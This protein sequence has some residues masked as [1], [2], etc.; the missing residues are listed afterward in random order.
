MDH[1]IENLSNEEYNTLIELLSSM[2]VYINCV[3]CGKNVKRYWC[4]YSNIIKNNTIKYG[5][6]C[7]PCSS[8]AEYYREPHPSTIK[9]RI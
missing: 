6:L 7:K 5:P 3:N 2:R 4:S 8:T 1:K 9:E